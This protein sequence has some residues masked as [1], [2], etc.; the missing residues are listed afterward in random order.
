MGFIFLEHYN[1]TSLL[2]ND[3][4]TSSEKLELFTDAS[5][6]GYA[7]LLDGQWFQGLWP[8]LWVD[9]NIAIKELFPIVL[10]LR[11]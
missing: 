10:A 4:W 2:L 3:L 11:I 7:G 6:F 1:G 8:A 9:Y 5:G